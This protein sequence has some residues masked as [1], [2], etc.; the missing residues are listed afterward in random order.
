MSTQTS[1]FQDTLNILN[2]YSEENFIKDLYVPSLERSVRLKEINAGQQKRIL[3]T[4]IET[5]SNQDL[6]PHFTKYFYEFLL[7]NCLEPKEVID[8]FTFIDRLFLVVG[9]RQQI[10]D[11]IKISFEG[12]EEEV[13]LSGVLENL[14]EYKHPKPE[15]IILNKGVLINVKVFPVNI[16]TEVDYFEATPNYTKDKK[17]ENVE[18]I[19]KLLTESYIFETSKYITDIFIDNRSLNFSELGINQKCTVLEKLPVAVIQK[20]LDKIS[21]WK[22]QTDKVLTV[23]SSKKLEKTLDI[24]ASL[25]LSN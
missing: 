1:I 23:K 15:T 9:A 13:S 20:T 16:K 18:V 2:T 6:R 10:S 24:D 5:T 8:N 21:S 17:I 11:S 3:N 12:E 4:V 22:T 7:E 19:K 25:F 14:L